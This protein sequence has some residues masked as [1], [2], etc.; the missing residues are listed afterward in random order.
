VDGR[1]VARVRPGDLIGEAALL[2]GALRNATVTAVTP[3]ELLRLGFPQLAQLA[4]RS[5]VLRAALIEQHRAHAH[6]HAKA[7]GTDA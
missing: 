7:V 6:E 5:P 3:I 4:D 1:E 2:D